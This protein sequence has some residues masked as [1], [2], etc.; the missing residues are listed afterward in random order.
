METLGG[1]GSWLLQP[2]LPLGAGTTDIGLSHGGTGAG[3]A[4]QIQSAARKV[5]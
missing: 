4:G 5:A 2:A 1:K 3:T